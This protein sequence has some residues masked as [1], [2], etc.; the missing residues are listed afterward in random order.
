MDHVEKKH[1]GAPPH[2]VR[3]VAVKE[4]KSCMVASSEA[5]PWTTTARVGVVGVGGVP[6]GREAG[7]NFA[8]G[9]PTPKVEAKVGEIKGPPRRRARSRRSKERRRRRQ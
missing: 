9:T 8:S 2:P 3:V 1:R 4:V 6:P 7:E 5:G